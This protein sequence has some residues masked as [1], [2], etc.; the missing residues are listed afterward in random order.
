MFFKMLSTVNYSKKNY[1][2]NF[3]KIVLRAS[4]ALSLFLSLNIQIQDSNAA[5]SKGVLR[6][7]FIDA[8]SF[9]T[10]GLGLL[11][12]GNSGYDSLKFNL[13]PTEFSKV[14]S[15]FFYILAKSPGN[16]NDSKVSTTLNINNQSIAGLMDSKFDYV[17]RHRDWF[18]RSKTEYNV[19]SLLVAG[20][21]TFNFAQVDENAQSGLLVIYFKDPEKLGGE[22]V[23]KVYRRKGIYSCYA[24]YCNTVK[25]NFEPSD[26]D[27]IANIAVAVT[28]VQEDEFD[29]RR[30]TAESARSNNTRFRSNFL[31]LK[32]DDRQVKLLKDKLTNSEGRAFDVLDWKKS[33]AKD[34]IIEPVFVP[35]GA[36]SIAVQAVTTCDGMPTPCSDIASIV[37]THLAVGISKTQSSSAAPEKKVLLTR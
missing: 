1:S 34:P 13:T 9:V 16:V 12:H 8:T 2:K 37:M 19:Q 25:I 28:E 14:Q 4:L 35:A 18:T 11:K 5:H 3:K 24:Q 36:T 17:T 15:A 29:G 33:H 23:D 27:R 7:E 31:I 21:N 22:V 6:D 26:R 30:E 20:E 10:Y 32:V